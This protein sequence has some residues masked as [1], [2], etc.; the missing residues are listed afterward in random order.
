MTCWKGR[1]DIEIGKN[2]SIP[3]KPAGTGP[4]KMGLTSDKCLESAFHNV[5]HAGKREKSMPSLGWKLIDG[6]LGFLICSGHEHE[7]LPFCSPHFLNTDTTAACRMAVAI[8]N[9]VLLSKA[10][11]DKWHHGRAE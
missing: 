3:Q 6:F 8:S 10:P 7:P 9:A 5:C 2:L 11:L 4:P 1:F